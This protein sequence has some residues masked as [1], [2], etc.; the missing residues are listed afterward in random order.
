[1]D[2]PTAM[3]AAIEHHQAGRLNEA[4]KVFTAI[5]RHDPNH[6]DASHRLAAIAIQTSRYN[7][8]EQLARRSVGINANIS[9][10][11][12]TLG[13]SLLAQRRVGEAIRSF[14]R[15]L[16]LDVKNLAAWTNLGNA[17]RSAGNLAEA[18]TAFR[19]AIS[20][21]PDHFDSH[22][23]L[24]EI[25]QQMGNPA[26]AMDE[27]RRAL[28]LRP[29][30]ANLRYNLAVALH[31]RGQLDEAITE[32]AHAVQA[33][34]QFADAW[35]NLGSAHREQA[36]LTAA[37]DCYR[38]AIAINP[39]HF[40]AW[41]NL[42]YTF[43]FDP[44]SKPSMFH[45][46]H[47]AWNKQIALPLRAGEP[48]RATVAPNNR[49]LRIGYVSP[50]YFQQAECFFVLPLLESHDRSRF[51]LHL[52][53]SAAT[54]DQITAR[55]RKCA[56]GWHDVRSLS[57]D[58][59][60]EKIRADGIDILVDLTM[61]MRG[62]RLL[63]FARKPAPIQFTWLAY[64]GSTGL[65]AIDFRFTDSILEPP[66]EFDEFSSEKPV[67]IE[68]GWI[69]YNPLTI[70]PAINELP[71]TKNGFITFGSLNN[72]CK[73][74]DAVLDVWARIMMAAPNSRLILLCPPGGHRERVISF[75]AARGIGNDRVELLGHRSREEYLKLY[76]RIDIG[77][78]PWPYNGITTT[79]D[80]LWMG[81]PVA[82]FPGDRP[83]G[84]AGVSLLNAAGLNELVATNVNHYQIKISELTVD[85]DRLEKLRGSLRERIAGSALMD[86]GR[87]TMQ[88]EAAYR[89]ALAR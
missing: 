71:A 1:M 25:A 64:P 73:T 70:E 50:D 18:A 26:V 48:L 19:S 80:A 51:E 32:Y 21:N 34:P 38:K 75:F 8:A 72:F 6:A 62:G 49:K 65:D 77:L 13:L 9:S 61:H 14:Q 22:A 11:H 69:C 87:F 27:Y 86:A 59:L 82:S 45:V 67:R 56:D 20:I 35:T 16:Q 57:D 10:Y 44:D 85:M 36:A 88:I 7:L 3:Q 33:N 5:L 40:A 43:Q 60:A 15:S 37:I 47:C 63:T 17:L 53:S 12:N 55:Y 66:G 23:S 76:H 31:S 78:D 24:G 58:A 29:K 2:I 79:C 84:R 74:N 52:Y 68:G 28:T 4:E 39:N 42:L 81:V 89:S 41:D 30:A 83:A 46:E 54:T